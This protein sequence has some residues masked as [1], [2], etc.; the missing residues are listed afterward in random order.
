MT[1]VFF[2]CGEAQTMFSVNVAVVIYESNQN[3]SS[4]PQ[5]ILLAA[6]D[7]RRRQQSLYQCQE[8]VELRSSKKYSVY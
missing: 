4:F 8:T 6:Q 1:E 7:S 5:S 2:V 3:D